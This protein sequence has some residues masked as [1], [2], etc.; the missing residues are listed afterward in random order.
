MFTFFPDC[1][2]RWCGAS[3]L[4]PRRAP[5]G[6]P[7]DALTILLNSATRPKY[8]PAASMFLTRR[9]LR[10]NNLLFD[11]AACIEC[12]WRTFS[13]SYRRLSEKETKATKNLIT[14]PLLENAPRADGKAVEEFTPKPLNR[15]IGLPKPPR[16][17]ENTGIDTRT[18]KQRWDDYVNYD[19]HLI[20]RK[21]M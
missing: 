19:K 2:V 9:P 1:Q 16:A 4:E 17:G 15:P 18:W 7:S 8:N 5:I 13:I 12:Q 14:Q 20:R 21:E 3:D 6:P 10:P 11:S